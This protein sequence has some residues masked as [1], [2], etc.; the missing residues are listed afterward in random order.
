M[1]KPTSTGTKAIKIAKPKY[2]LIQAWQSATEKGTGTVYSLS[3]VLRDSTSISTADP[4]TASIDNELSDT[5]IRQNVTLGETTFST[6]LEDIQ[7][8]VLKDICG[9]Q[10]DATSK[11][12]YAPKSYSDKFAEIT[13]VLDQ[14]GTNY[15]AIVLPKVQLNSKIILESLSS[16]MVGVQ[17]AGTCLVTEV[18]DG[19]NT[20]ECFRYHNPAYTLP[21]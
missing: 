15:Y 3:D 18:T 17:I 9:F 10:V 1:A 13:I 19:D 12:L 4:N 21:A 20:Y 7:E 8:D 16:S 11:K 6:T 2:I 5:P 14:G